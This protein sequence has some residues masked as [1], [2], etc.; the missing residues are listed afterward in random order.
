MIP[1]PPTPRSSALTLGDNEFD[2]V[3]EDAYV[4]W[5]TAVKKSNKPSAAASQAPVSAS[6]SGTLNEGGKKKNN[7][8]RDQG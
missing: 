7:N 5:C 3:L 1:R 2:T 6:S 4:Q 8:P